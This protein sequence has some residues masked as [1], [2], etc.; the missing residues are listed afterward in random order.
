MSR[1]V[2]QFPGLLMRG[3]GQLFLCNNA[4]SGIIF[5]IA[6]CLISPKYAVMSF[7]GASVVTLGAQVF[8]RKTSLLRTGLFG[9]NGV[10]FGFL[11]INFPEISSGLVLAATVLGSLVLV[12]VLVPAT[13]ILQ[14]RMSPFTVFTIPAV[15]ILWIALVV[16]GISGH[17]DT[18]MSRAW[19]AFYNQSYDQAE[20]LFH[21]L[22]VSCSRAEAFQADGLG[23][24]AFRRN[25]YAD[26][27]QHFQ[28]AISLDSTFGDPWDGAGWTE[29][30]RGDF[31]QA[32]LCFRQ[33]LDRNP[34]KGSSWD[35]LGW[36][37]YLQGKVDP[38]RAAF[39]KAAVFAP[40][41][42]DPY[43]GLAMCREVSGVSARI[44]RGLNRYLGDFKGS[45][46]QFLTPFQIMGWILFLTGI[47]LHSRLSGTIVI[48]GLGLAILIPGPSDVNL[49]YN[50]AALVLALGGAY[51]V[52]SPAVSLIL[53]AVCVI[54]TLTW[55]LWDMFLLPVTCL[56]FNLFLLLVLLI[57]HRFKGRAGLE[58]VPLEIAVTTPET[59]IW[60]KRKKKAVE[61]FMK[62]LSQI[63]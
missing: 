61:N 53:A 32:I 16:L 56:P 34:V 15:L 33:S 54:F 9:V 12:A 47:I 22:E 14:R 19:K 30:K 50:L 59:V 24:I 44:F 26:A 36:C 39:R 18:D 46:L 35:G 10:L 25:N 1:Y 27:M 58:T 11:W 2:K 5:L 57:C 62:V 52:L 43:L 45:P 41:F 13:A 20:G 40:F 29:F 6:L 60:W 4:V 21:N 49:Y 51:L 63:N 55:H 23:W 17:Y 28:N 3:Y 38:A 8:C 37:Y 48:F 31:D 42:D 7:I